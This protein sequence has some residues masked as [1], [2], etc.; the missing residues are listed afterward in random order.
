MSREQTSEELARRIEQ[1]EGELE[2]RKRE[3]EE[4]RR[5]QVPLKTLSDASF[6]ALFL[7]EQGVCLAHNQTAETM[8]GYTPAEAVGRHGVEWIAPEDRDQV[9]HN[10]LSGYQEP[11]RVTALR[12]DG[13]TFPC[14]I[15]ARTTDYQ[16]R[17]I[18]ITALRDITQRKRAEEA[19]RSS[20][21]KLRDFIDSATYSAALFD[22]QLNIVEVNDAHMNMFHP[23][24]DRAH[25]IGKNLREI[26]PNLE[27]TGRLADLLGVI[28]TG[29][30]FY[31]DDI[32]PHLKFG[33]RYLSLK[34]FRTTDGLGTLTRDVTER[35]K[36]EQE[37]LVFERQVQHAQKL[38]SLGVLA[39]GIA[40]DFN[41]LLVGILGY[42]DLALD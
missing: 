1:L 27:E 38:E 35:K 9:L 25:L 5:S 3:I 2:E 11:Y 32:V 10:M 14:E 17:S 22:S 7:S 33:D 37:K 41:N 24:M 18:R 26:V 13:T 16:G 31:A 20:Q 8:F 21:D 42:A 12:K 36:D 29:N 34:A 23:G 28:E 30:P 15:Q 6:E 4:L 39:G 19:L 40:H